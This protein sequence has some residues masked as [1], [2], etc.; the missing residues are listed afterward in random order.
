MAMA[1]AAGRAPS[2]QAGKQRLSA[3]KFHRN[4]GRCRRTIQ[5]VNAADIL[6]RY[7]PRQT[8]LLAKFLAHP[9][10]G[11]NLRF[12]NLQRDDFIGFGVSRLVN[13]AHAATADLSQHAESRGNAQG[14]C[15][16]F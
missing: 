16:I 11:G 13:D 12:Q 2:S 15:A 7:F 8:N 9:R 10:V 14:R 5:L 3:D 6:V 4:A 1:L